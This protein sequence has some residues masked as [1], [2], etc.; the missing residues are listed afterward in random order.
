VELTGTEIGNEDAGVVAALSP[1]DLSTGQ[2]I[3]PAQ[4]GAISK[5]AVNPPRL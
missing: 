5:G 4:T 2:R 3:D 1:D